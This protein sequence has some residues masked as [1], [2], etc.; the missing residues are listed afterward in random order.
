MPIVQAG[1]SPVST[2]NTP[3]KGLRDSKF[4]IQTRSVLPPSEDLGLLVL[5]VPAKQAAAVGTCFELAR[6]ES[7][8]EQ[9]LELKLRRD[10]EQTHQVTHV[11]ILKCLMSRQSDWLCLAVLANVDMLSTLTASQDM[12]RVIMSRICPFDT[13]R[14]V[15]NTG[16]SASCC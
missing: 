4:E 3:S 10:L 11:A 8:R 13:R 12:T 5:A 2:A 1:I 6:L 15:S 9:V 16:C 7:G 14:V